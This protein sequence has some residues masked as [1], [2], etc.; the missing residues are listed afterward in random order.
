[1]NK[2]IWLSSPH[3]G[4]SEQKY[5]QETFDSNWIAPMG[6]N[7]NEF[8]NT[9][10][11]YIGQNK[12]VAALSSGTA[13]IHMA[14]ILAG[15]EFG[16][17][18]LCQSFTFSASANPI[19]YQGAKP[20]FID[21]EPDTWNI[22]PLA[23]EEAIKIGIKKG[24]KPKAIIITHTHGMPAKIMELLAVAIKYEII[25][26][27]DAASALGSSYKGQKCG[28]FGDFGILSFNL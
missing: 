13:A 3:M 6:P 28:T 1:M 27:E 25:L 10:Q 21:S 26:I 12:F 9:I 16:D 2:K 24:K 20:I 7:V 18:V 23:L 8:E 19:I 15:V 22:C 14:L 4:G 11:N 5:V 17:E